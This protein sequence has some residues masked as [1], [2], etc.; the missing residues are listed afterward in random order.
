MATKTTGRC[1]SVLLGIVAG[2]AI[3]GCGART[4]LPI[5]DASEDAGPDA[6]DACMPRPL[7][8]GP[9]RAE[10]MF[11]VDRSGSMARAL[12]FTLPDPDGPT[13]WDLLRDAL[14]M[15][16]REA[17]ETMRIGAEQFP[18]AI[19]EGVTDP[20]PELTCG[21][22]RPIDMPIGS[23]DVDDLLRLLDE[24]DPRGGTPTAPAIGLTREHLLSRRT[25][26]PQFMVLATDGAPNC[27]PDTGVPMD[28]CVCSA[29]PDDCLDPRYG[30]YNCLDDDRVIAELDA[31]RE[32]GIPTFVVGIPDETRPDL[33]AVLDRMAVAGG[34]AREGADDRFYSVQSPEELTEAFASIADSISR[35]IY[36]VRPRPD[37]D[38]PL[39]VRVAGMAVERDGSH[40]EGWDLTNTERGEITLYGSTCRLASAP[41]V[42]VTAEVPCD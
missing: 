34:R 16:L 42:E 9:R 5:P 27:N 22:H 24:T 11:V 12:D 8:L 1:A 39:T 41:G 36:V 25:D 33:V 2:A 28:E 6:P 37:P 15:S 10:V 31:A 7:E 30:P 21:I 35:C 13:R 3:G 29:T 40:T 23:G 20:P 26:L 18:Q 17:D 4:G 14:R 19:P 38:E 32:A